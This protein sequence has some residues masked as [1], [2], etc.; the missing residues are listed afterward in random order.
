MILFRTTKRSTYFKLRAIGQ[1]IFSQWPPRTTARN[2]A[3]TPTDEGEAASHEGG[4][5]RESTDR[6]RPEYF[7]FGR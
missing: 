7:L 2:D 6:K 1:E 3:Q 4:P 5:C